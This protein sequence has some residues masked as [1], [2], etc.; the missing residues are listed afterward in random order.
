[1]NTQQPCEWQ[2]SSWQQVISQVRRNRLAH[3]YLITGLRGSGRQQFVT[4][5]CAF[6]LCEHAADS[7]DSACGSC[8]Q[9]LL[10][11]GDQHPDILWV[12]PEEGSQAIKIE[13]IRQL[14]E[15]VQ[16]T[17][18]QSGAYK[19]VVINPVAALA[20]AAAN[21]LLK[22]LEEPPGKALFLLISESSDN[23]LP[24][25]RSRCQPLPLSPPDLQQS[26]N[27]LGQQS[28]AHPQ[29]LESAAALAPMQPFYA[30]E[31][32]EQGIPQWRILLDEQLT[33]LQRGEIS[34]SEVARFCEKQ[35][36]RHAITTLEGRCISRLRDLSRQQ[37]HAG[38]KIS[39]QQLLAFQREI[40]LIYQQFNSTANV[41][42]LLGFEYLLGRWLGLKSVFQ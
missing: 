13:Q 8:R 22:S 34:V 16:Q 39:M 15:H 37:K 36:F 30:L 28:A 10:N 17:S 24:T 26:M 20:S 41:N 32:L 38:A 7:R 19:I 25:V 18:S 29:L 23:L 11:A 6:M 9:C 5:L 21:A 1:M 40:S 12:T 31:L 33:A 27:W 35:D 3:A 4:A 2:L 14:A 42:Q